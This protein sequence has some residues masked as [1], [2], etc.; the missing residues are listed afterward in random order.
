MKTPDNCPHCGLEYEDAETYDF[1]CGSIYDCTLKK[2]VA[3]SIHCAD[4]ERANKAEIENANLRTLVQQAA[5]WLDY[6][7]RAKSAATLRNAISPN[8][9]TD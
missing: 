4:R 2:V 7:G 1:L 6:M 9:L 5:D 8:S 3:R